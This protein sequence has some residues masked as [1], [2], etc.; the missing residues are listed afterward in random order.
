MAA[1]R[2]FSAL[3][4]LLH[5]VSATPIRTGNISE[6]CT[7]N[8]PSSYAALGDSFAA[9]LGSGIPVDGDVK[10]QRQNGSY[11][12]QLFRLN[13]FNGTSSSF[14]FVACSG[15]K[16]KDIDAQVTKLA[17]KKFDLITLTISGNDFGFGSIAE[18]CVY[19]TRSANITNPQ[20]ICD[21]ALAIGEARVANRSIWDSFD[22][23]LALIKSTS[24]N[25]GG[26][27]FVTGYAKFFAPPLDGDACDSISFFPIPQLAALNM[28]ASTRRRANSLVASVNHGIQKSTVKSGSDA[29]FINFDKLYEGRRFCEAKNAKDPI[30]SN[31]PNVFF[32][33]LATIL[34]VPGVANVTMQ[35]PGL[36]VDITNVLQQNTL[37]KGSRFKM[38]ETA[39]VTQEAL[40]EKI[41]QSLDAVHVEIEDMSGG[42]GQAY[43]AIIVSA[44]FEK[45]T[46]LARHRLVNTA[47]K[48]E[49]AA[50]HAWT[51]KC[52]TPE[53]W[54]KLNAEGKAVVA[55]GKETNGEVVNGTTA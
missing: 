12:E 26:R 15:D 20:K 46:T 22:Q 2:R 45:K 29:L 21:A 1:I 49:V 27:I 43:S 16:L 44:Q 38:A 5:L 39:G 33:D 28:T 6:P 25:T 34:P 42:C 52:Y 17:Q 14:N 18:A 24:L 11:P 31:N 55:P 30:G 35:T 7:F 19:Q 10:C 13:P 9:G 47:L 36:K 51:P 50:I 32:N 40:R 8:L 48:A 54:E 53:Q 3:L 23:K 37:A 41:M 4:A